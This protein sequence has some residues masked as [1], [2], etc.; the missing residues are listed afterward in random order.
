[1]WIQRPAKCRDC[2]KN[3]GLVAQGCS[4]FDE[5]P[6]PEVDL[7][8]GKRYDDKRFLVAGAGWPHPFP[9]RTRK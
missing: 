1:M 7:M 8:P 2:S 6:E 9:S 5:V 3:T 4:F